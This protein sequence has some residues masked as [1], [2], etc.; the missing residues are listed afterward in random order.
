MLIDQTKNTINKQYN[1]ITGLVWSSM[2]YYIINNSIHYILYTRPLDQYIYII[3]C[4]KIYYMILHKF[5]LTCVVSLEKWS[6][7]LESLLLLEVL[8]RTRPTKPIDNENYRSSRKNKFIMCLRR[9][10]FVTGMYN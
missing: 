2:V 10:G 8:D 9:C 4:G 3:T 1:I 5:S 7:G 6:S